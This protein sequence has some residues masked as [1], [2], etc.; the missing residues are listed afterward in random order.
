MTN[1]QTIHDL[2]Q[3]EIDNHERPQDTARLRKNRLKVRRKKIEREFTRKAAN[4]LGYSSVVATWI[5]WFLLDKTIQSLIIKMAKVLYDK[6]TKEVDTR[7][8]E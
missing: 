1:K 2:L 8:W 4:E 6:L 3:A 5:I 7:G